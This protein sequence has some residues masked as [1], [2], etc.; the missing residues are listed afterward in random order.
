[1]GSTIMVNGTLMSPPFSIT[2]IG[3][4]NQLLS[5]FDDPNQLQDIKQRRDV[6]GLGF[7]VT[8]AN[9]IHV[10]GF[11]GALNVRYAEPR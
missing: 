5:A 4:Q 11:S 2:V 8:R 6:Q 3:P 9:A 1:V 10:P 7:R